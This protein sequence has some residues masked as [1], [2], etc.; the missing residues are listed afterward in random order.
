MKRTPPLV[1]SVAWRNLHTKA[2]DETKEGVQP[3][4][5]GSSYVVMVRSLYEKQRPQRPWGGSRG[6]VMSHGGYLRDRC[7]FDV[8]EMGLLSMPST[9]SLFKM[10][11][12]LSRILALALFFACASGNSIG[13]GRIGWPGK[14][15]YHVLKVAL[16]S[17]LLQNQVVIVG[18]G[19]RL[20]SAPKG[21]FR[22]SSGHV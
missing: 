4:R 7:V 22:P 17:H 18:S 6:W 15:A 3:A 16:M 11:K 10:R 1:P 19:V 14:I 5:V 12:G 2:K 9:A 8:I 20:I 13:I 21:D